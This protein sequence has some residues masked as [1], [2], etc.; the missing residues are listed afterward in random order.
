MMNFGRFQTAPDSDGGGGDKKAEQST[1]K[2]VLRAAFDMM[3]ADGDGTLDR[4]EVR[5]L[6]DSLGRKLNE[7][8]LDEMMAKMDSDGSGCVDFVEFEMHFSA[9][10][11]PEPEPA[12]RQKTYWGAQMA[13]EEEGGYTRNPRRHLISRGVSERLLVVTAAGPEPEMEPVVATPRSARKRLGAGKARG[14]ALGGGG[15]STRGMKASLD[16]D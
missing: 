5:Q 16:I 7:T 10:P 6:S 2:A 3:D 11:Q 9:K 8:E 12:T 13:A 4:E 14:R 15:V 1:P